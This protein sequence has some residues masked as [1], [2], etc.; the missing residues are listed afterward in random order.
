MKKIMKFY[1][2]CSAILLMILMASC[3]LTTAL[4]D[5]TYS[6]TFREFSVSRDGRFISMAGNDYHYVF[7]DPSHILAELFTKYE[8]NL[9]FIDAKRTYISVGMGDSLSGVMYFGTM[10]SGLH[11]QDEIVLTSLGFINDDRVSYYRK[12]ELHGKRFK[13]N[14]LEFDQIYTR[15][16]RAYI[17]PVHYSPGFFG[18]L[19]RL[20]VTP[21]TIAGDIVLDIFKVV[22][23]PFIP[24]S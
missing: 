8:Q 7:D 10:F 2:V 21:V 15:L 19:V 20:P 3:T 13:A 11:K 14:S 5:K 24:S 18:S 22:F 6:E 12:V 16:G 23:Y 1:K 4:W 9:V 17:L